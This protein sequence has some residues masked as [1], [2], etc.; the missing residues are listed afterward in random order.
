MG[1]FQVQAKKEGWDE[2]EISY[3]LEKCTAGDYNNLLR[4]LMNHCN[5]ESES[6]T[7]DRD[8]DDMPDVVYVN[9]VPYRK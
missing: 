2:D 8:E 4:T 9:G 6:V 3:V 1:K 5:M 7:I